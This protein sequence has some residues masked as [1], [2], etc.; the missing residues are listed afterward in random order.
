MRRAATYLQ[1]TIRAMNI[2]AVLRFS[3]TVSFEI[4]SRA[5]IGPFRIK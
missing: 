3:Q 1:A 4:T 5:K 2:S